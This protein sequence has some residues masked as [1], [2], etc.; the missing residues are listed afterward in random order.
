MGNNNRTLKA[1]IAIIISV[2][3]ISIVVISKMKIDKPVFLKNYREISTYEY[4]GRYSIDEG[5]FNLQ[6]ITN[7]YD[8][9]Y[10]TGITFKGMSDT[11]FFATE[12]NQVYGLSF[13]EGENPNVNKHGRYALHTVYI[14]CPDL[15][16]E[17][18]QKEIIL[19]SAIVE[20]NDGSNMEIDLGKILLYK[21]SGT[22]VA[23]EGI[24]YSSS[25]DGIASVTFR[26]KEDVQIEKIES[27]LLKDVS[28]IFDF[29]ISFMDYD[30]NMVVDYEEGKII[31]ENSLVTISSKYN[32]SNDILKSYTLYEISPKIYFVNENNDRYTYRY[33]NMTSYNVRNY[34]SFYNFYG[35]YEYLKAR[36]EL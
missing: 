32:G 28:E 30:K 9:R 16:Y 21:A 36:E 6:Y 10:V 2:A 13:Y 17:D 18:N 23:L 14:S 22:P 5:F 27:T 29:N 15:K 7:I 19:T 8:T 11:Y 24:S 25:S 26:V 3:L 12:Y 1:S 35:I 4:D 31:E 33:N 20:F 34:S